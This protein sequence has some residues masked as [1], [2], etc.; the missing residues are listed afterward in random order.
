M[1]AIVD[2]TDRAL[3]AVD[4]EQAI[5]GASG[6]V[7]DEAP[8]HR[9]VGI[10]SLPSVERRDIAIAW[11]PGHGDGGLGREPN[12]GCPGRAFGEYAPRGRVDVMRC[13]LGGRG[14]CWDWS[15][16]ARGRS[17]RLAIPEG[18]GSAHVAPGGR[19]ARPGSPVRVVLGFADE[20]RCL[21]VGTGWGP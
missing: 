2:W 4:R 21:R 9:G 12:V 19:A 13:R 8:T 14:R 17:K 7:R 20:V 5:A 16:H 11:E 3:A 10:G 1:A 15:I 18:V 6:L